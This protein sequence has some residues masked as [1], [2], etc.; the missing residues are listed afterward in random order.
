MAKTGANPDRHNLFNFYWL[1][2]AIE[3]QFNVSEGADQMSLENSK[4]ISIK[5]L[6][7]QF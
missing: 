2:K 1:K 3:N 4:K 6:V 5:Q 7:G